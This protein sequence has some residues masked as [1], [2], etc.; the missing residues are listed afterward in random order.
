MIDKIH[1]KLAEPGGYLQWQE[2]NLGA[3]TVSA[4]RE[5]LDE[6]SVRQLLDEVHNFPIGR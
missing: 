4:V 3:L 2:L 5:G 6:T 1:A